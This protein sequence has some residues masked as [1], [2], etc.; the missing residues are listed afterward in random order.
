MPNPARVAADASPLLGR[1][2]FPLAAAALAALLLFPNLDRSYLWQDEAQHALLA[3]TILEH[4]VPMGRDGLNSLSQEQGKD[5]GPDGTFRYHPWLPFYIAAAGF[6]VLGESTWTAR[7]PFALIGLVTV[8]ATYYFARSLWRNSYVA[9]CAALLLIGSAPYLILVRQCR[10]YSPLA[11][12]FLLALWSYIEIIRGKKWA[13]F[14]LALAA[15][16]LMHTLHLF[17]VVALGSAVLHMAI[18]ERTKW[19]QVLIPAVVVGVVH[20]PWFMWLS[21]VVEYSHPATIDRVLGFLTWY[22]WR[23]GAHVLT[24]IVLVVAAATAIMW[25]RTKPQQRPQLERDQRAA[26]AMIAILIGM[27]LVLLSLRAPWVFFRYLSPYPP[28]A[29][30]LGA[31]LLFRTFRASRSL[32]WTAAIAM[33]LWYVGPMYLGK[34]PLELTQ[35][36]NGPIR[37]IV[38]YL[39][40]NAREGDVVLISYG[41]MPLKF[42][43]PLR[44]LGFGL[45]EESLKEAKTATWLIPRTGSP[46]VQESSRLHAVMQ[47]LM[48]TTR[49]DRIQLSCPDLT[50]ENREDFLDHHFV[51]PASVPPVMVYRRRR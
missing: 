47:E 11:L 38:D 40:K 15:T 49:F 25:I 36:H 16:L 6:A 50:Y 10:Y 22:A 18:W 28:L 27:G 9:A 34:Y 24:P 42:Y 23:M 48:R 3:R 20:I 19:K 32:G 5:I 12:F 30:L 51:T 17:A 46:V 43:T 21:E 41:D 1:V 8:V 39:N 13:P 26:A 29:A 35:P 37:S 33:A 4:G 31:P 45:M 7:L 44:V 2:I 14:A